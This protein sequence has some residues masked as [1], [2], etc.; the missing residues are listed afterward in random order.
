M[1]CPPRA[2]KP[3]RSPGCGISHRGI[4]E[5]EGSAA[6]TECCA[7]NSG[8]PA[9]QLEILDPPL[10]R[11]GGF[12][13]GQGRRPLGSG[14]HCRATRAPTYPLEPRPIIEPYRT[15]W[16]DRSALLRNRRRRYPSRVRSQAKLKI[17]F[18]VGWPGSPIEPQTAES[19]LAV[20]D[21][22]TNASV[23]RVA[24]IRPRRGGADAANPAHRVHALLIGI[25]HALPRPGVRIDR[26]PRP[27]RC[28]IHHSHDE[29]VHRCRSSL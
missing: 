22:G 27:L 29:V 13:E 2:T 23:T 8:N 12:G 4:A 15:C 26:A 19:S 18:F 3:P 20:K 16:Q 14:R 6:G 17:G 9:A 25:K 7:A 11:A 1:S 24:S 21:R 5:R 28:Q 10:I